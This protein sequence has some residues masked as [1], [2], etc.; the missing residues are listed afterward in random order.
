MLV[1]VN[2]IN[3]DTATVDIVS[4]ES[5]QIKCSV[6]PENAANKNLLYSSEDETIATS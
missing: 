4:G 6:E 3:V 1:P 2:Y 5:Y